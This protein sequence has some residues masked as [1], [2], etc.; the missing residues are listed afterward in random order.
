[1]FTQ[2]TSRAMNILSNLTDCRVLHQ[3]NQSIG[4]VPT[5]G[6]LHAGHASLIE[7]SKQ[8]NDITV[9]SIFVNRAQFNQ[10]SDYQHY[11]RT[12][13][14]DSELLST[15]KVDYLLLPSEQV[16]YPDGYQVKL[17][18]TEISRELE[19]EHRPGHF[20]GMLTVVL[21]LFNLVK[22]TRAYFGEKDYQQLLLVKKMVAAL[23]LPID[24]IACET[25]RAKDNLALSSRNSRLTVEHRAQ[26]ALFPMLLQQPI[27][28]DEVSKKLVELGFKVDYIAEKWGRR[29]GAVWLD[30]VRLIDNVAMS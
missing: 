3:T 6:N 20:D 29:L 25:Q 1:M 22:P 19:G 17:T 18:E 2:E 28:V 5:M 13:E 8:E 15:L 16:M 27:P 9:V 23:L 11:P 26:A 10:A 21:K 24:I 12:I 30:N 4:F 14:Q 7:R